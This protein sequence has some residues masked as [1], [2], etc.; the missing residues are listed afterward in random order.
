MVDGIY[1]TLLEYADGETLEDYLGKHDP[2]C[3]DKDICKF[4]ESFLGITNGLLAIHHTPLT[5]ENTDGPHIFQG[6]AH[7]YT[8]SEDIA[9]CACRWHQD[10]KPANILIKSRA[11]TSIYDFECKLADL[12]L[13]HFKKYT[14]KPDEMTITDDYGTRAYGEAP[15]DLLRSALIIVPGAPECFR[16]DQDPNRYLLAI[17]QNVDIWSLGC[18]ISEVATWVGRNWN[19]VQEYRRQRT[20]ATQRLSGFGKGD[21]C[22][23]DGR[24][25]S[26]PAVNQNHTELRKDVRPSDYVTKPILDM[27]KNDMLR[28]SDGRRAASY[29]Y[30]QSKQLIFDAETKCVEP[31]PEDP[32]LRFLGAENNR[33][34]TTEPLLI[35]P[36]PPQS[37]ISNQFHRHVATRPELALSHNQQRLPS[38]ERHNHGPPN[39]ASNVA[40]NEDDGTLLEPIAS[41]PCRSATLPQRPS[42]RASS[43]N[44][45]YLPEL[46]PQ[47][48][49]VPHDFQGHNHRTF[50]GR[51]SLPN[52]QNT[53]TIHPITG[54][55]STEVQGPPPQPKEAASA[56]A[57]QT[58]SIPY[59]TPSTPIT[60]REPPP[61]WSVQTAY[62]W[63][64]AKK[65]PKNHQANSMP[66]HKH[67]LDELDKRDHVCTALERMVNVC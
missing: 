6:Y 50:T 52:R 45:G 67:C 26:L 23:H 16:W 46:Q 37:S 36:D 39:S 4:W 30:K 58:A 40:E 29:I 25:E 12:G 31:N 57:G 48:E 3:T 28:S 22:F 13:S 33:G 47:L 20:I 21:C 64:R 63:K 24:D 35:P 2:P 17:R 65:D 56:I 38:R 18:V 51:S 60:T 10:I 53:D 7:G 14:A 66:S 15:F 32:H 43:I 42:N 55:K 19:S 34:I 41:V 1:H 54:F 5:Q 61:V 49:E 62:Q 11:N 8:L 9:Y 44:R 59:D 27:V